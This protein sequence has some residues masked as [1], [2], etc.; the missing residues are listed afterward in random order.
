MDLKSIILETE[1]TSRIVLNNW[2]KSNSKPKSRSSLLT[3]VRKLSQEIDNTKHAYNLIIAIDW[4]RNADFE[5]GSIEALY[6]APDETFQT[7][8]GRMHALFQQLENAGVS[9]NIIE[10]IRTSQYATSLVS[11]YLPTEYFGEFQAL[12]EGE[13]TE[14]FWR[15]FDDP[16]ARSVSQW[17]LRLKTANELY[18]DSIDL[19]SEQYIIQTN[20]PPS[21]ASRLQFRAQLLS[22]NAMMSMVKKWDWL[23]FTKIAAS[24]RHSDGEGVLPFLHGMMQFIATTSL[25]GNTEYKVLYRGMFASGSDLC[26]L[27]EFFPEANGSR[28][29]LID[30]SI[31]S[32]SWNE[33]V[34]RRAYAQRNAKDEDLSKSKSK[35]TSG[36]DIF[37]PRKNYDAKRGLLIHIMNPSP[38]TLMSHIKGQD[39]VLLLPGTFHFLEHVK[40]TKTHDLITVTYTP[41][42]TIMKSFP[43]VFALYQKRVKN[44]TV[45]A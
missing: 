22:E 18:G 29:S 27:D 25:T 4:M 21:T 39:E 3:T 19:P 36:D 30:K 45:A 2:Q 38:V 5:V 11:V 8:V 1:P 13:L 12:P 31:I 20:Q 9:S 7:Y 44:I 32:T 23:E 16:Y 24:M 35:S 14:I 42:F 33:K 26:A 34:A 10:I 15:I 37:A 6:R 40:T 41:D 17:K 28:K 43:G